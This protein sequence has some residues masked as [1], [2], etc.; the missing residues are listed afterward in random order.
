LKP[1]RVLVVDDSQLMQRI[2]EVML[3]DHPLAFADDGRQALTRLREQ[4]DIDLVLLDINMP[5]MDGRQFLAELRRVG[6]LDRV[7]VVIVTTEGHAEDARRGLEAGAAAYITKP[8]RSEEIRTVIA[9]LD[10]GAP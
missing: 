9:R 10:E 4:P 8:F 7:R 3:R 6:G 1:K 5:N 2:Y